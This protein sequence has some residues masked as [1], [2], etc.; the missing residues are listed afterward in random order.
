MKRI[1]A[2]FI[3]LIFLLTLCACQSTD[4][5]SSTAETDHTH[6]PVADEQTVS[7]PVSGYC[8]NTQTTIYFDGDK[9]YKFWGS[10]SVTMT[11][12]L[13]NLDYDKSKLCKCLPEYTVDTEF[14]AGYGIN[15]TEGYARC[16]KGQ[17]DLTQEQVDELKN[18]ILWAK[19]K[20]GIETFESDFS[21]VPNGS[22][23]TINGIVGNDIMD[24]LGVVIVNEIQYLQYSVDEAL[25]TPDKYLGDA[26][27]FD[28]TYNSHINELSVALY[29]VKESKNVL[30]AKLSNGGTV[31]LGRCGDIAVNGKLYGAT[32]ID[33]SQHTVG[34]FL[35]TA[36]KFE[37]IDVPHRKKNINSQDEI[38]SMK[39]YNDGLFIKTTDGS[40]VVFYYYPLYGS[41]NS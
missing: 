8:G 40:W 12:I 5:N 16:D 3:S 6:Q 24:V 7:D 23:P 14:G 32:Q 31:V 22:E 19:E 36:D 38:W 1:I 27:D 35:G 10:E 15:L 20:V 13:I 9:N 29:T 18:I 11:D 25:F 33:P 28:G 34:D 37:I 30:L 39:D 2:I 4:N 17:A 26:R 21:K 41:A